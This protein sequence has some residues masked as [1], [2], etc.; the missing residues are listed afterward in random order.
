MSIHVLFFAGLL[1]IPGMLHENVDQIRDLP[2]QQGYV[3]DFEDLLTKKEERKLK[4]KLKEFEKITDH[5]I[6]VV[7]IPNL[8][9][10]PM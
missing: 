9:A 3:N 4:R 2:L 6:V 1:M 8:K 5:E 10:I 7:T